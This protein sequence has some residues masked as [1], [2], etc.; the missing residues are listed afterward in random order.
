MCGGQQSLFYQILHW[1]LRF[2]ITMS[3]PIKFRILN[4]KLSIC[5]ISFL[6]DTFTCPIL[7][8]LVSLFWI[9]GDVPSGFQGQSGF[10]LIHIADM[11]VIYIP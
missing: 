7:G 3:I 9:S 2:G 5:I 4:K 10:C 11:N 1:L 8:Q 6:S